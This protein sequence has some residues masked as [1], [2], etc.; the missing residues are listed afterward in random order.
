M[1]TR[2]RFDDYAN[3]NLWGQ[4]ITMWGEPFKSFDAKIGVFSNGNVLF[5]EAPFYSTASSDPYTIDTLVTPA[6]DSIFYNVTVDAQHPLNNRPHIR[7]RVKCT[8]AN[9][10]IGLTAQATDGIVHFWNVVELTNGVGNWGMQFTGFG[11]SPVAGDSNYSISEPACADGVVAVA[12]Y[13]SEYMSGG[14]PAGGQIASFTS[15]GPLI[16]EEMKPDI[17]A[18]GVSVAS[19]VSSFTDSSYGSVA[20]VEFNG[21]DYNFAKFSGTSMASPC[22]AGIVALMLQA[23]PTLTPQQIKNVLHN[24]ARLDNHTGEITAPGDVR[25]GYGKVNAYQAVKAVAPTVGVGEIFTTSKIQLMPNPANDFFNIEMNSDN[26]IQQV[27]AISMDGRSIQL[28]VEQ[29]RVDCSSLSAGVYVIEVITVN[30]SSH[31]SL[32]KL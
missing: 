32:V 22:V 4:S 14:F 20:T 2:I 7:L 18:P 16:T 5:V 17:A 21:S 24:T 10:R 13:S 12:A 26:K 31:T 30:T 28:T 1:T 6:N 27:R 15:I 25:W 29:N 19:S 11:S 9:L 3:P 8:N 23:N